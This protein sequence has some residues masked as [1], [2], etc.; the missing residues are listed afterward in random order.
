MGIVAEI[1][2]QDVLVDFRFSSE[3]CR[4]TIQVLSDGKRIKKTKISSYRNT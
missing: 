4:N 1:K 2:K 3:V